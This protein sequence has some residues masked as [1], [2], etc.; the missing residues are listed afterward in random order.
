MRLFLLSTL[1]MTLA[2]S[3]ASC[4]AAPHGE[5]NEGTASASDS[6]SDGGSGS[7]PE[8]CHDY[9]SASDGVTTFSFDYQDDATITNPGQVTYI[10][11]A[12][13]AW[14]N[15]Y[16]GSFT[17]NEQAQAVITVIE[18]SNETLDWPDVWRFDEAVQVPL[19][20]NGSAFTGQ[21]AD[22]LPLRHYVTGDDLTAEY[23]YQFSIV[24]DGTWLTDPINGTHNFQYIPANQASD[25]NCSGATIS[26]API[27]PNPCFAT[28]TDGEFCGNTSGVTGDSNT[29]YTCNAQQADVVTPCANGCSSNQCN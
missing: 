23:I 14:L 5:E 20:W 15:V 17:G 19:T 11:E 1:G 7:S 16:R 3:A 6:R 26:S 24:I 13:P 2:A 8:W 12:T 10:N 22:G 25:A 9:L 28:T 29:L 21:A 27:P 18:A 4:S